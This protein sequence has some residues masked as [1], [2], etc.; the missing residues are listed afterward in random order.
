[1]SGLFGKAADFYKSGL[2]ASISA[3]LDIAREHLLDKQEIKEE[4]LISKLE[5]ND[6]AGHSAV[7]NCLAIS[8]DGE[9]LFSGGKD[10]KIVMWHTRTGKCAGIVGDEE[11]EVNFRN[12]SILLRVLLLMTGDGDHRGQR[13]AVL[14]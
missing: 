5:A 12:D 14:V 9:T 13:A 1:M 6:F 7:I 3:G 8:D 4:N 2:K 10:Q 11:S